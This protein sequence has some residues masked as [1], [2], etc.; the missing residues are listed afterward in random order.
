MNNWSGWGTV[1][2]LVGVLSEG[3]CMEMG[4]DTTELDISIGDAR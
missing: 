3:L 1:E 4:S 2:N